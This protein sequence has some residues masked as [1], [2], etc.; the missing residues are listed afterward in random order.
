MCQILNWKNSN[1]E[2][3]IVVFRDRSD[4]DFKL[5]EG[6]KFSSHFLELLRTRIKHFLIVSEFEL[7]KKERL[8]FEIKNLGQVREV[9]LKPLKGVRFW[10]KDFTTCQIINQKIIDVPDS[11]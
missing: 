5:S 10:N 2:I 11:E 3:L 7:K 9:E 1:G 4:F 8:D 6:V